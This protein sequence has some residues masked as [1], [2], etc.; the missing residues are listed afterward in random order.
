MGSRHIKDINDKNYYPNTGAWVAA[1]GVDVGIRDSER[2]LSVKAD[3]PITQR[4]VLVIAIDM[5]G[6][7]NDIE[8]SFMTKGYVPDGKILE[9]IDEQYGTHFDEEL[10]KLEADWDALLTKA[11]KYADDLSDFATANLE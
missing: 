10:R 4:R 1:K 7:P 9:T 8:A 6:D 3:T 11:R 2:F 5:R